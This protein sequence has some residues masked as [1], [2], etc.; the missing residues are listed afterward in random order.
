M[1]LGGC[2]SAAGGTNDVVRYNPEE[3][4]E[5]EAQHCITNGSGDA[6]EPCV[7]RRWKGRK[8]PCGEGERKG[9]S[10]SRTTNGGKAKRPT[11]ARQKKTSRKIT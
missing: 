9:D 8:H 10:Q 3:G 4:S 2:S 6:D 1:R 7:E 11:K 5:S